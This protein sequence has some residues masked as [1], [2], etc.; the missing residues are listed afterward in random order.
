MNLLVF[1]QASRREWRD[2]PDWIELSDERGR[3]GGRPFPPLADDPLFR[4][5]GPAL[6]PF[7]PPGGEPACCRGA[8]LVCP[9]GNYEFLHPREGAPIARYFAEALP[10]PARLADLKRPL[11]CAHP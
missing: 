1:L 11:S 8:V 4:D 10:L 9:G 5:G 7:L 3:G 2:L 6:L